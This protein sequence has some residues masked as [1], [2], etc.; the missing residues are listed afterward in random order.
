LAAQRAPLKLINELI[1]GRREQ[2]VREAKPLALELEHVRL[3]CRARDWLPAAG[4]GHGRQ[5]R[6]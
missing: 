6:L 4:R 2:R 3:E 1:R 5:R